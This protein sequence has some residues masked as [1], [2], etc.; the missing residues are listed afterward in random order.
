MKL[1]HLIGLLLFVLLLLPLAAAAQ[2]EE[3]A[4]PERPAIPYYHGPGGFNVPLMPG[5]EDRSTAD[6]AHFASPDFEA[7]VRATYVQAATAEAGILQAV[8]DALGG[9]PSSPLH[10]QRFNLPN[11]TWLYHLYEHFTPDETSTVSVM[12]HLRGEGVYVIMLVES[13]PEASIAIM[14][15]PRITLDSAPAAEATAEA[16]A[17][18]ENGE[19]EDGGGEAIPLPHD[20]ALEMQAV[21]YTL[22]EQVLEPD[23]QD[24]VGMSGLL[25]TRQVYREGDESITLLGLPFGSVTYVVVSE[26]DDTA[27]LALGDAFTL[28]FLGF[29]ITPDN[30]V[31]LLGGLVASLLL[32][33]LIP[34]SIWWRYRGLRK[35]IDTLQQLQ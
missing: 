16:D 20:P 27:A 6:Y 7:Y 33:G 9:A 10:S 11:G 34:L 2:D 35:E 32:L 31:Y 15:T 28:V 30:S 1:Q 8:T 22:T 14:P 29:F 24:T 26:G 19:S 3:T 23:E 17:A 18:A 12:G 13:I 4:A 25:W 21:L 5:W